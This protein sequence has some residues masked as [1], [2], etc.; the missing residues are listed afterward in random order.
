M[1]TLSPSS[2]PQQHWERVTEPSASQGLPHTALCWPWGGC[3]PHEC[4]LSEVPRVCAGAYNILGR[5]REVCGV[6]IAPLTPGWDL[7]QD[8]EPRPPA[9]SCSPVDTQPS[10]W[11]SISLLYSNFPGPQVRT[12]SGCF[13]RSYLDL[14]RRAHT[15]ST[16]SSYVE[17]S[18]ITE[19]VL[20]TNP[21]IS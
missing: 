16:N 6:S 5:S 14:H 15:I 2:L 3:D 19:Y 11:R 8:E 7:G 1:E 20:T 9:G 12:E 17:G 21:S 4:H 13:L 10:S 18:R